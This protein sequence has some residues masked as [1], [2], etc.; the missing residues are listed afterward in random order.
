MRLVS[1]LRSSPSA[2]VVSATGVSSAVNVAQ[3]GGSVGS[4]TVRVSCAPA[5]AA[6]EIA[7]LART[8]VSPFTVA[9]LVDR[10]LDR[11]R[12]TLGPLIEIGPPIAYVAK[13][14]AV[15]PAGA[16]PV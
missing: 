3:L 14:A 2:S 16:G 10:Q 5:A 8:C 6:T 11:R 12:Q 13:I 9:S 15:G 4:V 7:M 1:S